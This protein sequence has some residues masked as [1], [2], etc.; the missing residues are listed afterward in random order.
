MSADRSRSFGRHLRRQFLTGLVVLLPLFITLWFLSALFRLVDGTITPWVQRLLLLTGME[1]VGSPAFA[2]ALVPLIGVLITAGLIY[3]VGVLS[4]NVL[5]VRILNAFERLMLRIPGIRAVYG[6]SKQ[7]LQALSPTG[8]RSFREV[9][10]VEYP[11]KGCYTLGFITRDAVPD[12][13]PGQ[14]ETMAAVFLPT[15]PNPTSGWIIL[16]SRR[17]LI[18]L[19]LT[20]EEGVKMVVSGGI[21]M[22][23]RWG[24]GRGATAA[25]LEPS[26]P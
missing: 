20:V 18:S 15:A 3:C 25:S 4:N 2:S 23:E 1:A 13:V 19:P 22:P 21:V 24:T 17:E 26:A 11:R 10:L 14:S 6:G 12:L 16:V 9:V 8:K 7:L 5:G